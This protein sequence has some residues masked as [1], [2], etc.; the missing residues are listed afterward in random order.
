MGYVFAGF[1]AR[2]DAAVLEAALPRW[3]GCRGRLI[4][5]PFTGI[6]VEVPDEILT[7]GGGSD[8]E[9]EQAQELAWAIEDDLVEWS[10]HYPA[11]RFVFFRANCF[12]GKCMY[13][14]YVCQDGVIRE[15]ANDDKPGDGDALPRLVR[16]L[17]VDLGTPPHYEPFT[18]GFFE[19]SR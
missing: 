5:Q 19:C 13:E 7:Y 2:A 15:R 1:F 8:E 11:T 18:R 14:G 9:D 16:A 17:G 6:G 12:G 3:P 10:R 4:S